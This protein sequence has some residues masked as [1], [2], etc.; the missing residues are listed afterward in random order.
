MRL[1]L[2]YLVVELAVVVALVIHDRLRLDRVGADR[3]LRAGLRARR[4]AG[5]APHPAAA[6]PG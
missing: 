4:F 2:I 5:Q 6:A 1:F 3:Y